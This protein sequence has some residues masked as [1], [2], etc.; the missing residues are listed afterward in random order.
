MK[1]DWNKRYTK[2]AIYAIIVIVIS[3]IILFTVQVL[4]DI[5]TIVEYVGAVISPV[6][7]G[8]VIAYLLNPVVKMFENRVFGKWKAK[9]KN[10]RVKR[11]IRSFSIFLT[12][13]VTFAVFT[14]ILWLVLPQLAASVLAVFKKFPEYAESLRVWANE[15]F[16]D[17]PQ[18]VDFLADPLSQ[19]ESYIQSIWESAQP[20]L[21]GMLTDMG[22]SVWK[23]LIG[24]KDFIIGFII[25][26]Y[27]LVTK[28]MFA[29]QIKKFMFA[30]F[31]NSFCLK[32]FGVY[33][34]A[35]KIFQQYISGVILDAFLVGCMT[36][37]GATCIGVPFPLL[38]AV[39][40][41]VTNFI[42]FF[43]PF[44]GGIPATFLVLMA[45]PFK[46]VLFAL[47][48]LAM[49]QFDGNILV[50][51][52]QG[53]RT[54]VPS[55]WVLLAIII[56]GG[57]FGFVGMLLAVPV[58]AVIY[59]L[60]KDYIN[61]R[62]EKKKLPTNT[63]I[64]SRGIDHMTD[65]YEYTDELREK[66]EQWIKEL[67]EADNPPKKSIETLERLNERFTKNVSEETAETDE[68]GGDEADDVLKTDKKQ[69]KA[70]GK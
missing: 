60:T 22:S 64:Y 13:L 43:G 52:I 46:A 53:D 7:W 48:M 51:L 62:L 66:D 6:L 56:G 24:L 28:D 17:S 35:N 55:V 2:I 70:K 32:A 11:R 50:P 68:K 47:F 45:D 40:I 19:L 67:V 59:M 69:G 34:R 1:F 18:I 26:I 15:T 10:S 37:I 41:A 31:K 38:V 20:E 33:H 27:M 65:D 39:I 4:P 12:V 3:G 5:S 49:Q 36:F 23:I 54:G 57:M 16:K 21:S 30:F 25:A 9:A 14:S 44:I 63:L 61:V 42:P 58:F 8:I 29:V